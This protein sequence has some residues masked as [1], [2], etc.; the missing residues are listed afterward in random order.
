VILSGFVAN[1]TMKAK[2]E[3]AVASVEGVRSIKNGLVVKS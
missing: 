3:Q 1:E 2:A